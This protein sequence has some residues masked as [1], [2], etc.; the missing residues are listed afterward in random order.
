VTGKYYRKG[1]V[2]DSSL[3]KHDGKD[4]NYESTGK[5]YWTGTESE[6]IQEHDGKRQKS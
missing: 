1:T 4:K 6:V 5:C 3:E 2:S